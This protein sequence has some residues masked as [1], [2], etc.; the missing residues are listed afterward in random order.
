M[1]IISFPLKTVAKDLNN[2]MSE[3]RH[4]FSADTIIFTPG[5][6]SLRLSNSLETEKDNK[7]P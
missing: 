6:Q 5:C 3:I 7:L 4:T 1:A 2:N